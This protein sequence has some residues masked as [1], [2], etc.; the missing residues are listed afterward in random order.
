MKPLNLLRRAS[1]GLAALYGACVL[2]GEPSG[3][4]RIQFT[5]DFPVP[6]RVPLAG[7]VEPTMTITAGG[8]PLG[9]PHYRLESLDPGVVRV[10]PTG[11]GLEG[12]A[13]GT[14]SVRVVYPTATGA[15]DTVFPV[16]VV[17]SRVAIGL[18]L[19]SLTRLG[20]T[21]QL[22]AT[23][24]D[25]RDA[26]VPNVAFTWA[27]AD[28]HVATV[29]DTGLVKAVDEGT[30]AIIAEADSVKGSASVTVTQVAAAVRVVPELDTLRTVGRSVQ[31]IALA[32]DSSSNLLR[33]ARPHW[34]SSDST[35]A[36]V[37]PAGLATATG[38]G[39]ARI[40]ARVGTAVDTATLAV[41]QVIRFLVVTPAFDTLTA[42]ADTTRVA[43][44]AFDS[45]NFPI[46]NPSVGWATGDATI[47]TVDQTG[48]VTA[49]ANGAVLVTASG[50]GISG[51]ATIVL[52]QEVSTVRLSV[53]SVAFVGAGDT[54][55][56][57]AAGF[58][59][60]GFVVDGA[61][62]VWQ[63]RETFVA[64]VDAVGLVT[65][66]GDGTTGITATSGAGSGEATVTVAG[67]PQ[68]LIAFD[69]PRG[70][71]V[72]R[73]GGSARSVLVANRNEGSS[74]DPSWSP[75]GSRLVFTFTAI[76]V[77]GYPC[78]IYTTRADG[79]EQLRV[80][81]GE[82][83][84]YSPAWSPGGTKI[85]FAGADATDSDE[86]LR[87]PD[88]IYV[89][90]ADGSNRIQL[91]PGAWVNPTWSPDGTRL[92]LEDWWGGHIYVVNADGSGLPTPLI[93][94]G[95]FDIQL[96]WSPD[97]SQLAFVSSRSGN[98]DIWLANADGSGARNV[99]RS[100]AFEGA[101]AWSP[102]GSRLVFVSKE[103]ADSQADLYTI[104]VD[105]T[106]LQRLTSTVEYEGNPA[107]RPAAPPPAA[108][109]PSAAPP[110]QA[111]GTRARSP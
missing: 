38:A 24:Y 63:S 83:C 111:T 74:S 64:T 76:H 60:K 39:T 43:A 32:F 50:G 85:A 86:C 73:L 106:G 108:T 23:A 11:R 102:D 37:D 57:S 87:C 28:P 55:R 1:V 82:I 99:T 79:S 42:I 35:V 59:R 67:A 89:M 46:P 69:S 66:R 7:T 104:N 105:G 13:R 70:I 71:E 54:L 30:V 14:A 72:M 15:P 25:A 19:A 41:S 44:L 97:G 98:H 29:N 5:L 103:R 10:D 12:A 77:S 34:T 78:A 81:D 90:N 16:Q 68:P 33:S 100:L 109:G 110:R 61:E 8:Q 47:A 52:R 56:L 40:I 91:V 65:A 101:P 9:N 21:T 31:F 45:L 4:E 84:D 22:S 93:S 27:T 49:V 17:V 26:I 95:G 20:A 94:S 3:A 75:D 51:F 96:A 88:A 2:P 62:F 6:Y 36:S 53:D 80:S 18:P 58:D 107:W 92:A 48:L